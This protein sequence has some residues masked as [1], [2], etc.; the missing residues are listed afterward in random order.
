MHQSQKSK[1]SDKNGKKNTENT[2]ESGYGEMIYMEP[3]VNQM[4]SPIT[5]GRQ[6]INNARINNNL[7]N[8]SPPEN[9]NFERKNNS[10]NVDNQKREN[11]NEKNLDNINNS[12]QYNNE[13]NSYHVNSDSNIVITT[14]GNK[15]S[16]PNYQN[17]SKDII[18]NNPREGNNISMSKMSPTQNIDDFNSSGEKYEGNAH[19]NNFKN[20]L[21]NNKSRNNGFSNDL[22]QVTDILNSKP[23]ISR[24]N[25]FESKDN[26]K[27]SSNTYYNHMTYG[28][29][30]KIVK[31]F[32]QVYD[33]KKTKEGSLIN[34]K[35]VVLPGANDDVFNNRF[36]ILQKMNRLSNILLAK[37][38]TNTNTFNVNNLDYSYDEKRK[39]FNR[40]T[41]NRS[42]LRNNR[43]TLRNRSRS[44]ENKFLF[45]SLAMISSKGKN[46]ED[47][48]I[49]RNMRFEKGGVVDLAQEERKKSKKK[50][51]IKKFKSKVVGGSEN[52]KNTN[53][54]YREQAAKLIQAWWRE[55]KELFK[56]RLNMIIKIQSFWRGRWVRKYM[57]D[58]LY[59]SFMYQSF[60]Q[61]I[62]RVL[63]K[64]IRPIV[65]D[66]IMGKYKKGRNVLK[67]LLLKDK[68]WQLLKVKPYLERWR[69]SIKKIHLKNEVGRK[70]VDLR[71]ERDK[72]IRDLNKFF[73]KW[74]FLTKFSKLQG[75]N[76]IMEIQGIKKNGI[77]KIIDGSKKL[78]K[79]E[80]FKNIKPKLKKFLVNEGKEEYLKSIIK[81]PK[82]LKERLMKKYINKWLHNSLGKG[83]DNY[84]VIL[85]DKILTSTI[86]KFSN[87]NRR[88]LMNKLLKKIERKE[89]IERLV[90]QEKKLMV[91]SKKNE[92][93]FDKNLLAA[94]DT[95]QK[96]IWRFS[97]KDPLNAISNKL[98]DKNLQRKLMNIIDIR[99][100]F[101]KR[102]LSIT[103]K[104]W[105]PPV[106]KIENNFISLILGK[107]IKNILNKRINRILITKLN[108]WRKKTIISKDTV[109]QRNKNFEKAGNLIRKNSIKKVIEEKQFFDNLKHIT[110]E[111]VFNN[112]LKRVFDIYKNKYKNIKR[113][114]LLI[115][116]E[117]CNRISFKKAIYKLLKTL[118]MKNHYEN[119]K[120]I[121]N[122]FFHKWMTNKE[123][124]EKTR[125]SNKDLALLLIKTIRGDFVRK[126]IRNILRKFLK[127]WK[128]KKS[129][130]NVDDKRE[131]I[132]KAKIHLLNHNLKINGYDL[133]KGANKNR[134]Y[135]KKTIMLKNIVDNKEKSSNINIRNYLKKWLEIIRKIN[136][137][138]SQL[139]KAIIVSKTNFENR[140]KMKLLKAYINWKNLCQKNKSS[141]P[142]QLGLKHLLK[143]LLK[144]KFRHILKKTD[145]VNIN[146]ER[147]LSIYDALIKGDKNVAKCIALRNLFI[148][149]YFNKWRRLTNNVNVKTSKEEM[150]KKLIKYPLL[151]LSKVPLRNYLKKWIDVVGRLNDIDI[152]K[153]IYLKLIKNIK[154]KRLKESLREYLYRWR[155]NKSEINKKFG[156]NS[157][158]FKILRKLMTREI[159]NLLKMQVKKNKDYRLLKLLIKRLDKKKINDTLR[160]TLRKLTKTIDKE[161]KKTKDFQFLRN[162]INSR[163]RQNKNI[164]KNLLLN[165]LL[166][167]RINSVPFIKHDYKKVNNFRDGILVLK[168]ILRRPLNN[169]LLNGLKR[170]EKETLRKKALKKLFKIIP[171]IREFLLRKAL[172][173][174][175][176][177]LKDTTIQKN[178]VENIFH[179]FSNLNRIRIKRFEDYKCIIEALKLM[180]ENKN[181]KADKLHKF[182][183]RFA[184][185]KKTERTSNGANNVFIL[186]KK[187]E[188]KYERGI[189]RL[190]IAKWRRINKFLNQQNNADI[191]KK[192]VKNRMHKR[193]I[194][195][196]TNNFNFNILFKMITKIIFDKFKKQIKRK[197]LFKLLKKYLLNK[198]SKRNKFIRDYLKRWM[199]VLPKMKTIE[200]AL[201]IQSVLRAKKGRKNYDKMKDKANKFKNIIIKK[202]G[203]NHIIILSYFARWN[204]ITEKLI[205]EESADIIKKFCRIKIKHHFKNIKKSN[206]RKIFRTVLLKRIL[207]IIK[208]AGNIDKINGKKMINTLI[209]VLVKNPF[210]KLIKN[211]RKKILLK[212]IK[213]GLESTYKNFKDKNLPFYLKKF[214]DNTLGENNRKAK[215]IQ[216]WLKNKNKKLKINKVTRKDDLL[217]KIINNLIYDSNK[218]LKLIIKL[219]NKKTKY[220]NLNKAATD[221]QKIWRGIKGR[222]IGNKKII[223]NKLSIILRKYLMFK[224]SLT[225]KEINLKFYNPM[226]KAIQRISNLSKRYATNNLVEYLNNSIRDKYL[227]Q[228]IKKINYSQNLY[229][230]QKYLNKWK[231]TDKLINNQLIRIQSA[232]RKYNA[233]IRRNILE[234][235]RD[236][237]LSLFIK[238]NNVNLEILRASLRKWQLRNHILK[239]EDSSIIIQEFIL[240]RLN[241]YF[242]QR[243]NNF[244]INLMKGILVKKLK[245]FYK[246]N[247]LRLILLKMLFPKIVTTTIHYN[248]NNQID[249]ILNTHVKKAEIIRR[250]SSLLNSITNWNK[251]S[252][253]ISHKE[254]NS[255][256]TLQ[257]QL[258]GLFSRRKYS[259]IKSHNN[260][261]KN[262]ILKFSY[263][264][265][266]RVYFNKYKLIVKRLSVMENADIIKKFCRFIRHK[267]QKEKIDN[268]MNIINE[269]LQILDNFK[270]GRKFSLDKIR[271]M[272][273]RNLFTK[274]ITDLT[275]KRKDILKD[276]F[277]LLFNYGKDLLNNKVFQ[278]PDNFK[279]RILR[280]WIKVW[281]EKARKLGNL[282]SAEIIQKNWKIYKKNKR[283]EGIN[284]YLKNILTSL[285]NKNGNHLRKSLHQWRN[286][287]NNIKVKRAGKRIANFSI[288][289][290]KYAKARN[291]WKKLADKISH[292]NKTLKKINLMS[293]VKKYI[294]LRK[295]IKDL[296]KKFKLTGWNCLKKMLHY[297]YKLKSTKKALNNS[298][299]KNDLFK[300]TNYI[301]R[302]L[303]QI[304]KIEKREKTLIDIG[305]II[306]IRR[307][308]IALK[309]I[310]AVSLL[311]KL[312]HDL[313]RIRALEVF[314]RLKIILDQKKRLK[315]LGNSLIKTKYNINNKNIEIFMK[316]LH[317]IYGIKSLNKMVQN[318]EK[319]K[320]FHKLIQI[321]YFLKMFKLIFLKSAEFTYYNRLYG[322]SRAERAKITFHTKL[323]VPQSEKVINDKEKVYLTLTP[324][325]IEWL[326]EKIKIRH[327]WGIENLI[328]AYSNYK[329]NKLYRD[330][331]K[332]IQI[333][334]KVELYNKMFRVYR[335]KL[336]AGYLQLRLME[337][338]R[339]YAIRKLMFPL[340]G[341]GRFYR[342]LYLLKL[343]FMSRGIAKQRYYLDII[344]KWKFICFSKNM[345]KKKMDLMY[346]NLHLSYLQLANDVFGEEDPKNNVSVVKEFERFGNEIGMFSNENYN[347]PEEHKYSLISKRKFKFAMGEESKNEVSEKENKFEHQNDSKSNSRKVVKKNNEII[348][349]QSKNSE[350]LSDF[351]RENSRTNSYRRNR[352]IID[353]INTLSSHSRKDTYSNKTYDNNNYEFSINENENRP[354]TY[355]GRR[356]YG[357]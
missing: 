207:A 49:Y 151:K 262:T 74:A 302:W 160:N 23:T 336:Y 284:N 346:K 14:M 93:I 275:N 327:A 202:I 51:K 36:K 279:R 155:K 219:W 312:F 181:K 86:R 342:L 218:R 110:S 356:K 230:T 164:T 95:L 197:R 347:Q 178:K 225:L 47:R 244:F 9:S 45:V 236:K 350:E 307:H 263:E 148:R 25:L 221:I 315:F 5:S 116:K 75:N 285:L 299:K 320:H 55:L 128:A 88:I 112:I 84:K 287:I 249:Q 22:N 286:I 209:K 296:E 103:I 145:I 317:K 331:S 254:L 137:R 166:R 82:K 62:Q 233:K 48:T 256:L 2:S 343:T 215:K 19:F 292:K 106:V 191:I 177:K 139:L 316:K 339:K 163:E 171:K 283:T 120:L 294:I 175:R 64:F 253:K 257:K 321:A 266:L 168:Q 38:R 129:K 269:A 222:I 107:L 335:N 114:F 130:T 60:C 330:Y 268:R 152:E 242:H 11:L 182:F 188:R 190:I 43:M 210:D 1:I 53:P 328:K 290:F 344:R 131:R 303:E 172:K 289:K 355:K 99:D 133:L 54:K 232:Y 73:S 259:E 40:D 313:P 147:G 126:N 119:Q 238:N 108:D 98:N 212:A 332:R 322:G 115:W 92:I 104:K 200:A 357:N 109:F 167:W 272:R 180:L 196:K 217:K 118:I 318:L 125:K 248:T 213:I 68:Y 153:K 101:I 121:L 201:K 270:P 300:L 111:K 273:N 20:V 323:S 52:I 189:K 173:I 186:L 34:A 282:R 204:M 161:G 198:E 348:E 59:L 67:E 61:I 102:I 66:I 329:F 10:K 30:K 7:I 326:S 89:K 305:K 79:K 226:K 159:F 13:T 258:R 80:S 338:L 44:P 50:Y 26:I 297:R 41:L 354:N 136:D 76:T 333:A 235:T 179:N 229:I 91:K 170:K 113:F 37:N 240:H 141:T 132:L 310:N 135:K 35:Q 162:L 340:H 157:D 252:K 325:F 274:V 250:K 42:T 278:I 264:S 31:R 87:R 223:K 158:G 260:K 353:D 169:R 58:I 78:M 81:I 314:K 352:R 311:K 239:C 265:P 295:I 267:V 150:F 122:K 187:K 176:E 220:N 184:K 144:N 33:P 193:I 304:K 261:F 149:P 206:L 255:A 156:I 281:A 224:L 70:L 214:V 205:L 123:H 241:A 21:G 345:A 8:S 337:L 97:Y 185:Q 243:I 208:K 117:E 71:N 100:I 324:Y 39:T 124:S 134:T 319:L 77:I 165:A 12:I 301:K 72:K 146:V 56:E 69:N 216:N 309:I 247:K 142:I 245:Y 27:Y 251:I 17:T 192:Y 234:K 15:Q 24:D 293:E 277:D 105:N 94:A 228:I 16:S 63:V 271:Q 4:M 351:S 334:Q 306:N 203:G 65:F 174:W 85:F 194:N 138:E 127:R 227:N 154:N 349:I 231:Q 143:G 183:K 32:T 28:D 57:Y 140:N 29:V 18:M 308:I 199:N 291:N 211:M 288:H 341:P 96:A 46:A 246:F 276:I 3:G 90:I 83:S 6:S 280:K 298:N 237:I 195:R